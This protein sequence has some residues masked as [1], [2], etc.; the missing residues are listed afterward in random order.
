MCHGI[1][2]YRSTDQVDHLTLTCHANKRLPPQTPFPPPT[3]SALLSWQ[4]DQSGRAVRASSGA[5]EQEPAL[6]LPAMQLNLL[7]FKFLL[8]FS[9]SFEKLLVCVR[10]TFEPGI[11]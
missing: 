5:E 3:T 9:I 4:E 6:G 8:Q 11:F 10:L 2:R 7:S 1:R